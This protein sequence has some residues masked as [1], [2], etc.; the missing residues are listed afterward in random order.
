LSGEVIR[1][2]S[3]GKFSLPLQ[4]KDVVTSA[5]DP[6]TDLFDRTNKRNEE[7]AGFYVGTVTPPAS[8][9][10]KPYD[11]TLQLSAVQ[12]VRN[13]VLI[14]TIKGHYHRSQDSLDPNVM[15]R[16]LEVGFRLDTTPAQLIMTSEGGTAQIPNAYYLS[17]VGMFNMANKTYEGSVSNR[18]GLVGKIKLVR[19]Q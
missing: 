1:G 16:D 8:S 18:M 15:D 17:I 4:S 12:L 6:A 7:L 5:T 19:K 3:L 2:G 9:S 14:A 13:G 10:E 11:V